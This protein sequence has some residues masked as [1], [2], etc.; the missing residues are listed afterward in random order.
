M[1]VG[2]LNMSEF[3]KYISKII[4]EY[5]S[6]ISLKSGE[7]YSVQLEDLNEVNGIYQSLKHVSERQNLL[8]NDFIYN[9]EIDQ[10]QTFFIE[11]NN[12]KVIVAKTDEFVSA[13]FLT[14]L[15]N[16]VDKAGTVFEN[17]ALLFVHNTNLDSILGGAKRLEVEGMPLHVDF[18]EKNLREDVK[19]SLP[20]GVDQEIIFAYL[21]NNKSSIYE[22]ATSIFDYQ[23]LFDVLGTGFIKPNKYKDF[24]LFYDEKLDTF[25]NTLDDRSLE[26]RIKENL[27]LFRVVDEIHKYSESSELEKHFDKNGVE[28]L[29]RPDWYEVGYEQVFK[30]HEA[31]KS[32]E[33]PEYNEEI[34]HKDNLEY[35]IWDRAEGVSKAKQR[36]RHIIVFNDQCN[37]LVTIKIKFDS[38]IKK[39][40]IKQSNKKAEIRSINKTIEVEFS[41]CKNESQRTK[42]QYYKTTFYI[43]VLNINASFLKGL[44]DKYFV[45]SDT[46][47]LLI[48]D[49]SDALEINKMG[50]ELIHVTLTSPLDTIQAEE[51]Q[52]IVID[53]NFSELEEL[54]QIQLIVCI[55]NTKIPLVFINEKIQSLKI[56]PSEVWKQKNLYASDFSY[57]VTLDPKSNR[58]IVKLSIGTKS[59]Y[60]TGEFRRMLDFE[61]QHIIAREDGILFCIE[62]NEYVEINKELP[63]DLK[64][65]YL[66]LK[67][68]FKLKDTLP[69]LTFYDDEFIVLANTYIGIYF[70]Y[71]SRLENEADTKKELFKRINDIGVVYEYGSESRIHFTPLHPLKLAYQMRARELIC[72][73]DL[74][75]DVLT[76]VKSTYLVPYINNYHEV[77][78]K[79]I[80]TEMVEWT[81]YV[82]Y[83]NSKH[84][85]SNKY[86]P[87]IVSS[88][89]KD[90]CSHF[91][92]LFTSE[93]A[94]IKVGVVNLGDCQ[95]VLEGIFEYYINELKTKRAEEVRPMEIHIYDDHGTINTFEE[96]STYTNIDE[97]KEV[98][99]L[100]FNSD[101]YE[102]LDIMAMYSNKVHF[103]KLKTTEFEYNHVTFYKMND[104]VNIGNKDM[105]DIQ[106]GL[107]LHGINSAVSSVFVGDA[108]VTGFGVKNLNYEQDDFLKLVMHYNSFVEYINKLSN[109]DPKTVLATAIKS[110]E[111]ELLKKI[112][113]HSHWITFID[114][115]V[116]LN[117]F[118]NNDDNKDLMI[119][120]Y[121]DQYSSSNGYDA[122]TVTQK[123]DIYSKIIEGFLNREAHLDLNDEYDIKEII[124]SFN[125]F[126]GEWL[127]RLISRQMQNK[128]DQ[129]AKEKLSLF[130]AAKLLVGKT[131]SSNVFWIPISLEEIVRVSGATG[132]SQKD[133]MFNPK[134]YGYEGT[135]SDDILMIGVQVDKDK[136]NVCYYPVEVKIGNNASDVLTKAKDQV[137][138]ANGF[139]ASD[140]FQS[141]FF[142]SKLLRNQLMQMA[143]IQLRKLMLYSMWQEKPWNHLLDDQVIS[144]LMDDNYSIVSNFGND[145]H[146][147]GVIT[148]TKNAFVRQHHVF[149]LSGYQIDH[150]NY[151]M[152]DAYQY[153]ASD[154]S[155]VLEINNWS[156]FEA[157]K[158]NELE[159]QTEKLYTQNDLHQNCT[160]E[161]APKYSQRF[162]NSISTPDNEIRIVFGTNIIDRKEVIWRPNASDIVMHTNTGIIGTMGTGKTQFT[163]S[164]ITQLKQQEQFNIHSLPLGILIF[165]YKGDYIK[166]D[167]VE[168]NRAT[169]F[170]LYELPFN[171]LSIFQGKA[172]K[173]MLP[174]HTA[175]E[176]RDTIGKAFNLGPVQRNTLSQ[177]LE[178]SYESMGIISHDR[179]T[180]NNF[181][182]TIDTVYNTY[183]AFEYP[184]NDSLYAALSELHK[185]RIFESDPRKTKPLFDLIKGVTVIDLSGYS[186]SIQN[187]VVA[188]TLD[189]FY[190]QM[191]AQGHSEIKGHL[192]QIT[193]MIL[194]DEADN[195][196]SKDF[197]S[198]KK[199]L[200]EGREFGVGTIISTQ[201]LKHFSTGDNEFAQYVLTW[202]IHKVNE[203]S[204]KEVGNI[205]SMSNKADQENLVNTIKNLEKHHSIVNLGGDNT[206][207]HIRD[208]AFWEIILDK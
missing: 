181:A 31:F 203:I 9:L 49:D 198:I 64:N 58:E 163:K 61:Y 135:F 169:V 44:E 48:V 73:N 201:F 74:K 79:P 101:R 197:N 106:T 175:N 202:I 56:T 180:W 129:F 140:I 12:V 183:M 168:A 184:T 65:A 8:V 26:R 155:R 21:D 137:V 147:C 66:N 54:E 111:N 33:N 182:P 24:G 23:D 150:F 125:V 91:E 178:A 37:D 143:I 90:F 120:H 161:D 27:N 52:R 105:F 124:N 132:L 139:F 114:P 159:L 46:G 80:E 166:S 84:N 158:T 43:L 76:A 96:L 204:P 128:K 60:P 45:K 68:Y 83:S 99:N 89:I 4:I 164:L 133:S 75:N 189:T 1:I 146:D 70:G 57:E 88:K 2:T 131:L 28:K 138:K 171:P 97:I 195:F 22:K 192:R 152:Q 156:I 100:K 5:L 196:L 151:P 127:L 174:L 42:L 167:F 20:S 78:F 170:N 50:T 71:L 194:V 157:S 7:R 72:A 154:L 115:K 145:V 148:F 206:V 41:D 144:K 63:L 200:K 67:R 6:S 117:Y 55:K 149:E 81:T 19:K 176:L 82:S 177:V 190:A 53:K 199:I 77:L 205:F 112:Y 59:Y 93:Y 123:S 103:Y 34:L 173:P 119:I 185:F 62:N 207:R 172:F 109:F 11:I 3:Y 136:I 130:A 191:Q 107:S 188:I 122:I 126:N 16:N 18:I 160:N 153:L 30:S 208:K 32:Q 134:K 121:S 162:D 142:H 14:H 110:T 113:K 40:G 102:P 36:K 35:T 69:S 108:Y 51:F 29:K 94:P 141:S 39:E 13:D 193:K 186:E 92:Y 38:T 25:F 118:K 87:K 17:T 116:D 179:N 10:Y 187:L 15:R 85:A 86:V 47:S 104:E 98:F 95:Q 165:D